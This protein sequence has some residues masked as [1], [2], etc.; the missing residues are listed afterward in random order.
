MCIEFVKQ[1]TRDCYS[2]TINLA[3]NCV[4]YASALAVANA[5]LLALGI[6]VC[7]ITI[8]LPVAVGLAAVLAIGVGLYCSYSI[9]TAFAN[10]AVDICRM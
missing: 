2:T 4:L 7:A 9:S 8:S 5:A 6:D 10:C 1:E 3:G